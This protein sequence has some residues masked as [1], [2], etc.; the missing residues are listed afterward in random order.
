MARAIQGAVCAIASLLIIGCDQ[1]DVGPA[2]DRSSEGMGNMVSGG[3]GPAGMSGEEMHVDQVKEGVPGNG[4]AAAR[5][6]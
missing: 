5:A 2:G 4:Q 3:E 1:S 6:E